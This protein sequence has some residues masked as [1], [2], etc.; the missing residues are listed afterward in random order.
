MRLFLGAVFSMALGASATAQPAAPAGAVRPITFAKVAARIPAGTVWAHLQA[1]EAP[2]GC[3]DLRVLAWQDHNSADLKSSDFEQVFREKVSAAGFKVAGDPTNLFE[4]DQKSTDL[5]VGAL[6]TGLD[7]KFCSTQT[8]K[9]SLFGSDRFVVMG[10]ASMRIEWQVYSTTQARIVARIPT[11]AAYEMKK[12]VDAGSAVILH[13]VFAANVDQLVASD[14]FHAAISSPVTMSASVPAGPL[15][16]SLR[17]AAAPMPLDAAAKGVVS[18][19]AGEGMGSGVL[20]SVDGYILTN[21][22]VAGEA[23]QVRIRWPDGAE[24]VG[25]VVRSDRRRDVALIKTNAKAEPLAIRHTPVKLGETVF[26]IGTPLDR[27]LAGTLTR[28]IVSTPSRTVEGQAFIQSDV[29]VTHGNSGGPLLDEKGAII[30]L[31]EMGLYPDES[32]SLNLFIPIDDALKALGV[33]PAA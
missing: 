15:S 16:V 9:D 14:A 30:G 5:Q 3:R 33:K 22:H 7:A 27:R 4:E 12:P 29:A 17:A 25:E 28:G 18:V 13:E 20:I 6:V 2:F 11:S 31:T 10:S 21:H 32:K 1:S 26:A 19:F 23:G 24:T 8:F